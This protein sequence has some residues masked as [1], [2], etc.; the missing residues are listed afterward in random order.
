MFPF[1][2]HPPTL[3]LYTPGSAHSHPQPSLT[4]D[5]SKPQG[6]KL[7]R[8]RGGLVDK[9]RG[10]HVWDT[11]FSTLHCMLRRLGA[12]IKVIRV[13]RQET[14]GHRGS[15]LSNQQSHAWKQAGKDNKSV[16]IES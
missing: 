6:K 9:S 4:N 15:T 13:P 7:G 11:E 3:A 10:C 12:Y 2:R 8:T 16:G 5:Y 14:D 1:F